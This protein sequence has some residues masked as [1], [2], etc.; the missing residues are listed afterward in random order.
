MQPPVFHKHNNGYRIVHQVW[1]WEGNEYA[2]HHYLTIPTP[3]GWIVKHF[4]SRYRALR[5]AEL[6]NAL[7]AT[8]FGDIRWLEPAETSFYQPMVV[9]WKETTRNVVPEKNSSARDDGKR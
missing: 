5:R 9:A 2:L 7:R 4:A 3:Q 1:H 6:N 8:G